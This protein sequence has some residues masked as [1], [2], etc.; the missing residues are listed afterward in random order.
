MSIPRLESDKGIIT[1]E[2]YFDDDFIYNSKVAN[3]LA[4]IFDGYFGIIEMY[5]IVNIMILFLGVY[6]VQEVTKIRF[7]SLESAS[8]KIKN[9]VFWSTTC[10]TAAINTSCLIAESIYFPPSYFEIRYNYL[11]LLIIILVFIFE[12]PSVYYVIKDFKLSASVCCCSRPHLIRAA[13]TLALCHM[14]WFIHRV[15]CCFIV[16]MFFLAISPASTLATISFV[17]TI[18]M[19]AILF[20]TLIINMVRRCHCRHNCHRYTSSNNALFL[21][22]NF[23]ILFYISLSLVLFFFYVVFLDMSRNGLT[24]SIIGS[25]VLSFLV[26]LILLGVSLAVKKYLKKNDIHIMDT[27]TN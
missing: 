25:I 6:S 11:R 19:C 26:P 16:S 14:L 21:K 4:T 24:S 2:S 1:L 10:I 22:I 7:P 17:L 9:D 12:M 13:Y 27:S 5:I 3:L 15:G 20:M 18:I 8:M 23:I